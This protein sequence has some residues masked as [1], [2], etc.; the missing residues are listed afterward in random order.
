MIVKQAKEIARQWVI[1]HAAN[2]PGFAGAFYHGSAN[3]LPDEAVL[4]VTSDLDVMVVYD[5]PEPP[6]KPGKFVYRDTLLEVS[7]LARDQ[8]RSPEQILGHYQLAGSFQRPGVIL[9]PMGWLAGFTATVARDYAKRRWVERRCEHARANTRRFLGSLNAADPFHDQVTSWLFGTGG[10]THILI[11]AGLRNPTVRRRYE[12][13]RELLADYGY[14]ELYEFLLDLLG[15]A[16][17]GPEQVERHLSALADAFDAAKSVIA[18]PF[19]FA[20]DI[21]DV[22]RPVAIDGSRE[23]ITTGLH[24]EAVFWIVATYAR[25]LKVFDHDA[26]ELWVRFEPGFRELVGELGINSFSD[27]KRRG[28]EVEAAIPRVWTVAEAIVAANREIEG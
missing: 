1:D 24:R 23:L 10:L 16:R 4:P 14:L 2:T 11:V 28:E 20:A 17:L 9:D 6:H 7:S 15:A 13:A 12:A 21:S 3:W 19:F 5:T 25:C 26:P 8:L 22:G 27:M 18:T